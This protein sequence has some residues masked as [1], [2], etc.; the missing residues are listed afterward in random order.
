MPR[1]QLGMGQ[2][3][4]A[5]THFGGH[6]VFENCSCRRA[7][8]AHHEPGL[9]NFDFR[10]RRDIGPD[11]ARALGER[12]HLLPFLASDGDETEIADAGPCCARHPVDHDDAK[13]ASRSGNGMG[14]PDDTAPNNCDVKR[15]C[16]LE[17]P[18]S[19]FVTNLR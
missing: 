4:A 11:I 5:L 18:I 16:H 12:P 6:E 17:K 2:Q 9:D 3:F 10:V 8:C 14:Q 19:R 13:A 15:I 7:T 1:R